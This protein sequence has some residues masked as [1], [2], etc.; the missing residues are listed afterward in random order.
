[1]AEFVD[2]AEMAR[3]VAGE[4]LR[5]G[6]RRPAVMVTIGSGLSEPFVDV[7]TVESEVG[8][9]CD[10]H[11]MPTGRRSLAFSEVIGRG[12]DVYGGAS[13]VYST[14][15]GWVY[16]MYRSPLRF[17]WSPADRERVTR[18]L[19]EDVLVAV[20]EGRARRP[21]TATAGF[22]STGLVL[23]T[24]S[25]RALVMLDCAAKPFPATAPSDLVAPRVAAE[26]V[27]AKG[28]HVTGSY[29]PGANRLDASGSALTPALA[30]AGVAPDS[31]V[32]A[33]VVKGTVCHPSA[34][35]RNVRCGC[36][37]TSSRLTLH[38]SSPKRCT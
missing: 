37:S 19:I 7:G 22:T 38:T 25:G 20:H 24:I 2:T 31:V 14:D 36:R 12:T 16:D 10:V 28:Q 13:R 8:D 29:D 3:K 4:L 18:L 32:L 11:V 33:Q 34:C 15:L 5:E 9:L 17:A 1:M 6:L 26:R 35:C 21:A 27:F 23:G 30:F